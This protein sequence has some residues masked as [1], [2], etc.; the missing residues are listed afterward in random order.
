MVCFRM[1]ATLTLV[2]RQGN[3]RRR[4]CLGFGFATLA[5]GAGAN[6]EALL[7]SLDRLLALSVTNDLPVSVSIDATQW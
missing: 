1:L 4:L 2:A 5:N 3:E 7:A 6:P